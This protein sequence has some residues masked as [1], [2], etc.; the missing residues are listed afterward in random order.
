MVCLAICKRAFSESVHVVYKTQSADRCDLCK[1]ISAT[2]TL[3]PEELVN[4]GAQV[5]GM[6]TEFGK[7][8]HGSDVNYCSTVK[9]GMLLVKIDDSIYR[10]E[11]NIADAVKKQ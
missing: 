1:T 4:V 10:A 3:E 8:E 11:V 7:D 6:I 5:G 9:Q 2:G